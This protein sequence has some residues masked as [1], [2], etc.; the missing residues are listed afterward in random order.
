[1]YDFEKNQ[2]VVNWENVKFWASQAARLRML[3]RQHA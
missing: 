1:M 3:P 2:E